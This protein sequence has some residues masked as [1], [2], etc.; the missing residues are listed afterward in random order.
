MLVFH[1]GSNTILVEPFQSLHYRHRIV[2]YRRIMTRLRERGHAVDLD[3][4]DNKAIKEYRQVIMKIRKANFQ[5]V[6][7]DFHRPNAA[8]QAIHTSKAHFIAILVGVEGAFPSY[9]W[10][11]L[12]TQTKITLNLIYQATLALNISAW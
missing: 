2:A 10:Y 3:V 8:E 5:I 11:T 4:L 1:C 12:L 9:L 6:P 7:P